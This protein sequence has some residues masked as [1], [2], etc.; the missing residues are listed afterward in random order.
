MWLLKEFEML[1][2]ECVRTSQQTRYETAVM[3][4]AHISNKCGSYDPAQG[5]YTSKLEK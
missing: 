3:P 1:R 5:R 4:V 2:S